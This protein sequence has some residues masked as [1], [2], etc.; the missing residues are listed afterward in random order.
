MSQRSFDLSDP[1]S[2]HKLMRR[3]IGNWPL[4]SISKM[5]SQ[6][7]QKT[8]KST[9]R[10]GFQALHQSIRVQTTVLLPRLHPAGQTFPGSPS[11]A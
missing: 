9:V 11:L 6:F 10:S 5:S 2:H 7:L 4:R 3:V 8:S 1:R